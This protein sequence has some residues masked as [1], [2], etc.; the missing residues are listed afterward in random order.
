MR[1]DILMMSPSISLRDMR[2]CSKLRDFFTLTVWSYTSMLCILVGAW[3]W[4]R[5]GTDFSILPSLMEAAVE[6]RSYSFLTATVGNPLEAFPFLN[7]C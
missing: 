5:S 1:M 2:I 4:L 6:L 3:D 7:D